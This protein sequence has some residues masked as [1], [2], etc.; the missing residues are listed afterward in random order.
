MAASVA[1]HVL[2]EPDVVKN[3]RHYKGMNKSN[4]PEGKIDI[5]RSYTVK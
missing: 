3:W 4:V 5:H 2:K 1:M